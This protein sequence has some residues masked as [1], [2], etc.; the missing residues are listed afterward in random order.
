[1]KNKVERLRRLS[2]S[3]LID[4]VKNYRQYGYDDKIR[5]HAI[6]ILE[7]RGHSMES[8]KM[9]GDFRNKAY[10]EAEICFKS[11]EKQSKLAF[12]FY[13]IL[14][15]MVAI[16]LDL[17]ITSIIGGVSLIAFIVTLIQSFI[18]HLRY[19]KLIGKESNY[20]SPRLYFTLGIFCYI[21]LYFILRKQMK[22]DI[23]LI[24]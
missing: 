24:R 1:M 10:D 11:F 21:I 15:I 6:E 16:G 14:L 17:L 9:R 5:N 19:Y 7:S 20:L 12:L 4:V 8:L 3:R 23:N 18:S 2:D 13:G 22:E